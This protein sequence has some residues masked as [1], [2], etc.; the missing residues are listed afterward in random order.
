MN[1]NMVKE[2]LR[3]FINGFQMKENHDESTANNSCLLEAEINYREFSQY[4][5]EIDEWELSIELY[6]NGQIISGF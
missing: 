5:P 1:E 2:G 4:E 3:I 6:F